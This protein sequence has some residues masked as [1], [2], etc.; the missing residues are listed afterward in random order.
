MYTD[1]QI[2]SKC[3]FEYKV[4]NNSTANIATD[5]KPIKHTSKPVLRFYTYLGSNPCKIASVNNEPSIAQLVE[6][7]TVVEFQA[8]ILR[9]L[10]QIRLEGLFLEL[11][12]FIWQQ[13][14]QKLIS[15]C[16][17]IPNDCIQI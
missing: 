17:V 1:R 11:L 2:R 8:D 14:P 7:R 6:R 3:L 10:V 4:I 12:I 16:G 15:T 5:T 13:Q 9:S